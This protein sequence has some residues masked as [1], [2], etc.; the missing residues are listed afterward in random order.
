MTTPLTRAA[1][2]PAAAASGVVRRR[3]S[4]EMR[5]RAFI[6]AESR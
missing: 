3:Q 5:W 6:R 4:I 2:S 1:T